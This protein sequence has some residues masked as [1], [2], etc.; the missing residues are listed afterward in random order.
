MSRSRFPRTVLANLGDASDQPIYVLDR[1][2]IFVYCNHACEEWLGLAADQ[3]I[4]AVCRL[5]ADLAGVVGTRELLLA[6]LAPPPA[7]Y[8]GIPWQGELSVAHPNQEH[9]ERR[10][11]L[12]V[13]WG[14]QAVTAVMV[15][16]ESNRSDSP[17]SPAVLATHT[18]QDRF[19]SAMEWHQRLVALATEYRTRFVVDSV[20]GDSPSMRRVRRQIELGIAAS[21]SVSIVGPDGTPT[22]GIAM[23]IAR[24]DVTSSESPRIVT[25][26][27]PHF[28]RDLVEGAIDS[29]VAESSR[30]RKEQKNLVMLDVASLEHDIQ[31][32][33]LE[34][35]AND[36]SLRVVLTT[37]HAVA[38]SHGWLVDLACWSRHCGSKC[39]R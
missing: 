3:L 24:G 8:D 38:P 2:G 33:L 20:I 10:H 25:L 31:Y 32:Y 16:V 1:E 4:G 37:E 39:R 15:L 36:P 35:L 30:D 11:V 34:R 29:F 18:D 13:P 26:R 5:A 22:E 28:D 27:G 19:R 23:N 7:V 6:S 9:A 21:H 17:D 12:C 14:H